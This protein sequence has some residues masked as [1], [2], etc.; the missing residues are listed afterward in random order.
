MEW[1]QPTGDEHFPYQNRQQFNRKKTGLNIK[2]KGFLT[3]TEGAFLHRCSSKNDTG[4]VAEI[5]S[6]MGRSTAFLALSGKNIVY[7]IDPHQNTYL[8]KKQAKEDTLRDFLH[9]MEDYS[10]V[11]PLVKSSAKAVDFFEDESIG[12]M[13]IDGDHTFEGVKEDFL[14]YVK[15]V[16]IGGIIAFHDAEQLRGV[17]DFVKHLLKFRDK[18]GYGIDHP[19]WIDSIFWCKRYK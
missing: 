1:K 13:F 15:K 8:H 2:I 7:A 9:N 18:D 11:V 17:N 19:E 16:K 6:W 4:V 3:E 14:N 5:G 10:N 12:V